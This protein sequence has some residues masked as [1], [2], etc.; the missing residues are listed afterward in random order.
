MNQQNTEKNVSTSSMSTG[1]TTQELPDAIDSKQ[2]IIQNFLPI[3]LNENIDK[4][5]VDYQNNLTQL[6]TVV[7]TVHVFTERNEAIDFLTELDAVNVFL[8]IEDNMDQHLLPL[9]HDIPQLDAI[10]I[11][12]GNTSQYDQWEEKWVKIKG[13]YTN[14]QSLCEALQLTI[15][16]CN[17]DSIAMSFVTVDRESSQLNLNQIEPTFMYSQLFK[18]I[19]L[20]IE[21]NEQSIK[22]LANYCRKP[23]ENN[24]HE[25]NIIHEFEH[26]YRS[27]S[28]IWWYTRQCFIYPMLNRALRTLEGDTIV[29]M[30]FFIRDLHNQIQELYQ[31]QVST[32]GG[33]S[34][35]VYRG[36]GL[37]ITDFE[38]LQKN[39]GGLISFNNLLST[40]TKRDVS[41]R[42]TT[43]A[44]IKT[45]M[46]GVLF[47]MTI[48]PSI[49]STPFASIHEHSFYPKE[50]E[51]LFSMHT[52]FRVH[53]VSKIDDSKALYEVDLQL[54]ADNDQELRAL[55]EVIRKEVVGKTRWEKLG[56]LLLEIKQVE[57]AE[58]L[59]NVLLDQASDESNQ[60]FCHHHLGYIK[61][62]QGNHKKAVEHYKKALEIDQKIL[63]P[64]YPRLATSY[65]NIG[66]AYNAMG[67]Y[68]KALS[69]L[70]KALEIRQKNLPSDHLDLA[71]S[72]NN[73]GGVYSHMGEYSKALSF[74][75]EALEIRQ[76]TLPSDHPDLATSY[77]NVGGVYSHMGEYSK[78]LS[79]L[80]E[81]L[82]IRQKTLP[83]NYPD[84][85]ISYNN[86]GGV[87]FHMEEYSKAF[88]FLGKALEIRQKTLPS[89]HPDLA[90]SYNN[91]GGVYSHTGEYS[92]ALLFLEKA[93]EI[94]QK[95][96]PSNHPDLA[97]SYNNIGLVYKD[98][99]STQKHF[100]ILS[101]LRRFFGM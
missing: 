86:I 81:A 32:Y 43:D 64:N 92:K 33:Q 70:G 6:Q 27:M 83:P 49:S 25:L 8:L 18:E 13:T 55:T 5:T 31:N 47:R 39:I 59:Y 99:E 37:F 76:K 41:L 67:E 69:F 50:E 72:Y 45:G 77:N 73:T 98:M 20:E 56:S 29:N 96:L 48:D 66:L 65:N 15:E 40:S 26:N 28:P 93:L 68:S 87:Y 17:Q 61:Y 42:F 91:I 38:K 71:I 63:P 62:H 51:I 79:F 46:V 30:G 85:A 82:E 95:T 34:F 94:R 53:A 44:L 24:I 12:S 84:L 22:Y 4:S 52:V 97:T 10:Y 78:A 36:Q 54:T 80:G 14:I 75:G 57:K 58:E 19:I 90:T 3:W 74:L 11:L 101:T 89:D 9:I 60:A 100:S 21:F 1:A 7:H 2:R 35:T 16:Q 88:S 23:Y